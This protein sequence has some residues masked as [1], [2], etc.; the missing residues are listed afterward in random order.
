MSKFS[1]LPHYLL[2]EYFNQSVSQGVR[3]TDI[4]GPYHRYVDS[5]GNY[6]ENDMVGSSLHGHRKS[7]IATGG[8]WTRLWIKVVSLEG[9]IPEY[10]GFI[11]FQFRVNSDYLEGDNFILS[12]GSMLTVA[13]SANSMEFESGS[14]VYFKKGTYLYDWLVKNSDTYKDF[15]NTNKTFCYFGKIY[16]H[17]DQTNTY[18]II[19][20]GMKNYVMKA[21]PRENRTDNLTEFMRLYFDKIYHKIYNKMRDVSS[22]LDA[23]EIDINHIHYIAKSYLMETDINLSEEAL[24]E[25]VENLVYILKRKGTYSSLYIIWK[26]F[27]VNSLNTLNIYN[28][29]HID[30]QYFTYDVDIPLGKFADILHELSYGIVP[31]GCAGEYY[32]KKTISNSIS[33]GQIY[34]QLESST[35]WYIIHTMYNRN[36]IVQCYD[37]DYNRMWPISVNPISTTMVKVTFNTAVSGFVYL[38]RKGD[39]DH[40]QESLNSSWEINHNLNQKKVLAQFKNTNYLKMIPGNVLLEDVNNLVATFG[41]PTDG[42]GNIIDDTLVVVEQSTSATIWNLNHNLSNR[43]VFVQCYDSDGNRIQSLSLLLVDEDNCRSTFSENVSGYAVI[44]AAENDESALPD[45]ELDDM[46]LSTHYKVEMDLSCEPVDDEDVYILKEETVDRLITNWELMRPVTRFSHYH[47]LISPITDFSGQYKSLYGPGYNASLYTK[48][49][50]SAGEL[51]PEP[52]TDIMYFEQYSN[53][54]VWYIKHSLNSSNFIIQCYN[55]ENERIWPDDV[56]IINNSNIEIYFGFAVNGIACLIETTIGEFSGSTTTSFPLSADNVLST[57]NLNVMNVLNQY[58]NSTLSK[59]V[60]SAMTLV[61]ADNISSIWNS[62]EISGDMYSLSTAATYTHIQTASAMSWDIYHNLSCNAVVVQFFDDNDT[63]MTPD[64]L[65][66]DHSDK[67]TATFGELKSGYAIIRPVNKT[68]TELDIMNLI[69]NHGYWEIGS[70]TSGNDYNPTTNE[71][72]ETV[73]LMDNTFDFAEDDNYYYLTQEISLTD[74][75]SEEWSVTEIAWLTI[76]NGKRK[77]RFYSYFSPIFKPSS[78]WFT[79]HFRIE[80]QQA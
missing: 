23:R 76:I 16:T 50:I 44:K 62:S 40:I 25:W 77:V 72:V 26:T 67:C 27:L 55:S 71:G 48:F 80:K 11:E 30:P 22:L 74:A 33:S 54:N 31:E 63:L 17:R 28:R 4:S 3:N 66:M 46:I 65:L 6:L 2:E 35:V 61:D 41:T 32:Y 13:A 5:N 14:E 73:L 37:S 34:I 8:Y 58:D 52:D 36:V 42:I 70:G 24:R 9:E 21:L 45:Y 15:F 20:D 12:K 64:S 78:V 69:R 19:F 75:N 29:W 51:A 43:N 7:I 1:D 59:M 10:P 53:A 56:K 60:P 68:I 49:C 47:E 39:H 79:S 18:H 38:L 57:H